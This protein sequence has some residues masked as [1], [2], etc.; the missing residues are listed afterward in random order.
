MNMDNFV[1][2]Q[3]FTSA[4]SGQPARSKH[5]HEVLESAWS[6]VEPAKSS[7]PSLITWSAEMAALLGIDIHS[8]PAMATKIFTGNKTPEGAVPYAMRYGGHQFG[9]WAGQLGDGRAIALGEVTDSLNQ[10]WTLQLKGAGPT[11]YSRQGDGLAVLRSSIREY[12]CSEAMHHLGV[13]TTR[14]LTLCLTGETVARDIFYDGN[15]TSEPGAILCRAAHSFVR[16][17]SF[18][19]HAAHREHD[20][21]KQL[22]NYVIKNHYAHLWPQ[23]NE[24]TVDTYQQW[25]AEILQRTA[26]LMVHW[27]RVGFV[28]A[29]MNTD[30]MSILGQTIDYGPYGWLEEFDP[31][32]T[33]SFIDQQGRRYSYGNQ[34]QMALWNLY[35]LAN[36]VLPLFNNDTAPLEQTLATY[37][38]IFN[39]SWNSSAA[40]KIGISRF[41]ESLGD[42]KLLEDLWTTLQSTETDF[43]VFFRGLARADTAECDG[44][45]MFNSLTAAFYNADNLS[46]EAKNQFISWLERWAHRVK[47]IDSDD[48]QSLMNRSNPKYV[49]RN[50][51]AQ[52]AIDAAESGDYSVLEELSVV[53]KHPYDE[54]PDYEKYAVARPEWAS[55]KPGSTMLTCSS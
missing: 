41:D 30:N 39:D 47:A 1:L 28:H 29:V 3:L 8:D 10:N 54:Q 4:N 16:F 50:Y 31:K 17:G 23:N 37:N 34:P 18:E 53:L 13:P 12:L 48:R 20:L 22:A 38:D 36:A 2:K 44:E 7:K 40:A 6:G 15:V 14:S 49:L 21:L 27:Q 43:T 24:P 45:S 33:P 19:I 5:P 9:N 51:M 32:W 42:D 11:P 25:F 55:R 46:A 26:T 35:R 52:T